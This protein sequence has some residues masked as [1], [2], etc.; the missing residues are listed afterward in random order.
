[1]EFCMNEVCIMNRD[2]LPAHIRAI[3][4]HGIRRMEIRKAGLLGYLRS[5]GTL[6]EVKAALEETGMTVDCLN[7]LEAVT[8]QD[9][10]GAQELRELAEFL[11]YCCRY[12]NCPN[13]E[14]IAA[15]GAPTE[16][17]AEIQA[18]TVRALRELSDLAR[19]YGVKL[20]LEYMGLA[21]SS[22]VTF[23]QTLEIVRETGRDNVGILLD[24]W[25]HYAGGSAAEDILQAKGEE[26]F[27]VHT[28]DCPAA[29]P[30]TTPRPLSYLP[31]DGAVDIAAMVACLRRIGYDG[32]FSVEVM[33][34]ALLAMDTD[35][36]LEAA[37][38][39]TLPLLR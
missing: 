8:F 34:P 37:R 29:S 33:D 12:L 1:M 26:I 6:E 5:G 22:V 19:P 16:D 38:E 25:H 21:G 24:T 7:A 30:L 23:L 13:I 4:A 18:E 17:R 36:F 10:R 3:A 39:K 31:G 11:F 35:A 2:D 20:A 9:A 32:V 27:V 14:L 28:S 15:F